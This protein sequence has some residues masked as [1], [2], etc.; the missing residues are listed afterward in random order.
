MFYGLIRND[1]GRSSPAVGEPKAE[2]MKQR[3]R[4]AGCRL[5]PNFNEY[6]GEYPIFFFFLGYP[7]GA[8][9]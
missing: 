9:L 7:S 1:P 3:G 5:Q 8:L 6:Q 2:A 4:G